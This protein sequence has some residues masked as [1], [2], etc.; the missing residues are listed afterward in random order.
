[1]TEVIKI[2]NQI[3]NKELV[4]PEFQREF[5]WNK[6][7]AKKLIASFL[8]DF[9]TGALLFWKTKEK[10]ALKNMPNFVPDGR[11]EVILDGQQRLTCLYLLIK[12]DIPQYYS[13]KD[14]GE[15]K[16]I[17]HL[18]YNLETGELE[19]YK[20]NKMK[21]NPRWV[22]VTDCFNSDLIDGL[23]IAEE[24]CKK[25]NIEF[26]PIL[27]KI[28]KN[29]T[30]LRNIK[31]K[32]Y[33]II[34]VKD[35][36]NLRE[37]LTVFDRINS[38]GTPLTQADIALAHMCSRWPN[39]RQVF[40][41]K[42]REIK[43]YGFEFNL[44][45]LVRAINA[46]VNRQAEYKQLHDNTE[47]ELKEGFKKLEGILD[48]LVNILRDRAYIYGTDDLNTTNV[49]IPIIG[50]LSL[51]GPEF[52]SE[53][54]MK[55]IFY[56][57]YAALYQRRFSSSVE[58]KLEDDLRRFSSSVDQKLED[59]L[60]RIHPSYTP[61]VDPIDDLIV[62]LQ[63]EQGDPEVTK[64]NLNSRGIGHP[65]YDMT[66]YIIRA[67]DGFDWSTGINLSKPYGKKYSI[68]CHHIFPQSVLE[69]NGYEKTNLH[70]YNLIHEIANRVPLTK[71][72]NMEIFNK[73]PSEYFAV[74]EEKYPGNLERFF[75]PMNE[76]LWKADNYEHFLEER[77]KLIAD[78]INKFMKTLLEE[79]ETNGNS[80]DI[81]NLIQKN[82]SETLEFK[83]SLRW[84]LHLV[85]WDKKLEEAVLKT[86]SSFLNSLGGC[87]LIGVQDDGTV[88]GIEKDIELFGNEDKYELHLSNII[89]NRIGNKFMP[90]IHI[91]FHDIN[92][93]KICLV[94]VDK[95]PWP[96]YLKSDNRE[97][98]FVRLGNHSKELSIAEAQDYIREHWQ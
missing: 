62:N 10:I 14:I 66:N 80:E 79:K 95:S 36:S 23:D 82:E 29:L 35:N 88:F 92:E 56:W 31:E 55:K 43:E 60:S 18:H 7:Q 94:R 93:N 8:S 76:K 13:K 59:D 87:L 83:S 40:K 15:G 9:P 67:K 54:K 91:E 52:S 68:G 11:V 97:K 81:A 24:I 42:I 50:Y 84:N 17:R 33:K 21:Y 70:H 45:F 48:Y 77:R 25:D 98:Y 4:L 16:D 75:I 61:E 46:V 86:I 74:L 32:D 69:G 22:K 34:Y 89:E 71:K 20:K 6:D 53:K 57:M 85:D 26:R 47:N 5:T 38:A 28:S 90:Y 72:S 41:E 73:E 49:L 27:K 2:L 39:T 96:N 58:Q 78:G 1:M 51:Y 30:K 64:S 37:A 63:E 44:T 19:Y 65:L 12:D 3:E